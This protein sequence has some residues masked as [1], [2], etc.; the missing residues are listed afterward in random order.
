LASLV[1]VPCLTAAVT[2]VWP[3]SRTTHTNAA[4]HLT[5]VAISLHCRPDKNRETSGWL[6]YRNTSRRSI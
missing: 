6:R 3:S 1:A 5:Q 2:W 4:I